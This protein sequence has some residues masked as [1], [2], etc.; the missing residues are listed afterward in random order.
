MHTA[1]RYGQKSNMRRIKIK[2]QRYVDKDSK[3]FIQQVIG[4]FL[5]YARAVDP[6]ML[7]KLNVI[8]TEQPKLIKK[9]TEKT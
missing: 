8:A 3:T 5:Y 1:S 6:T 4:N 9:T 2:C 7:V